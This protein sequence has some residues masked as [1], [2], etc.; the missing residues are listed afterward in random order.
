MNFLNIR[1]SLILLLLSSSSAFSQLLPSR[2]LVTDKE[3]TGFSIDR[4]DNVF[5]AFEGGAITKYNDAL[6]SMVSFS[7]VRV[8]NYNLIEAWH[9]FQIFAFNEQFQDYILLDRFLTRETRF[10]L[11]ETGLLFINLGTISSDQNLWLLEENQLLLSKYNIKSRELEISVPLEQVIDNSDHNFSFMKEYQNLLFLADKSTGIYVF[12]NLGNFLRKIE[13]IGALH[14]SFYNES[15]YFLNAN[16][17]HEVNLYSNESTEFTLSK[18]DYIGVLAK[19]KKVLLIRKN[20]LDE[21]LLKK[22]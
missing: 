11:G 9:G 7:S 2:S 14:F 19:D 22:N 5:I 1:V 16:V 21:Y 13:T 20:G 12:D 17:L 4:T 15:L 6:D 8:G 3:I 10:T 18:N